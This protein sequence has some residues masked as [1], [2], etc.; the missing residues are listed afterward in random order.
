M[1][2]FG[3]KKVL[4]AKVGKAEKTAL[5]SS[6]RPNSLRN[7]DTLTSHRSHLETMGQK[8]ASI[9]FAILKGKPK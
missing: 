2:I 6:N 9:G 3:S 1:I 8:S 7:D 5:V 4:V